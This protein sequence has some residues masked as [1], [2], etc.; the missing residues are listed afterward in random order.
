M[1][2]TEFFVI[3]YSESRKK[4]WQRL[5]F[6]KAEKIFFDKNSFIVRLRYTYLSYSS[7]NLHYPGDQAGGEPIQV[8]GI[9]MSVFHHLPNVGPRTSQDM[10]RALHTDFANFYTI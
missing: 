2:L 4:N 10:D 7:L 6:C 9:I 5:T 8:L 3:A 1:H